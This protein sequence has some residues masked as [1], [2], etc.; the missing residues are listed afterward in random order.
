[1]KNHSTDLLVTI[2]V[3]SL[4]I[5]II[6][7]VVATLLAMVILVDSTWVD[8]VVICISIYIS[9]FYIVRTL[10]AQTMIKDKQ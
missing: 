9:A 6:T 2:L 4:K 10:E 5:L 7:L 8:T 1:M 3:G